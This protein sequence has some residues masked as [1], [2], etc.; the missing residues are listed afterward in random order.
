M[1]GQCR[2]RTG[3]ELL[4]LF[5]SQAH[6]WRKGKTLTADITEGLPVSLPSTHL[7][8]PCC[9]LSS[10][11]P[12]FLPAPPISPPPFPRP[13]HLPSFLS[14]VFSPSV[15]LQSPGFPSLRIDL[16]CLPTFLSL[17]AGGYLCARS[18]GAQA[19]YRTCGLQLKV[20]VSII[21]N[22]MKVMVVV[23]W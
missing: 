13:S 1:T 18:L 6:S 20:E 2:S 8:T 10:L 12:T 11:S 17:K 14:V 16:L 3:A 4:P 15:S 23:V 9:P 19:T 7:S 22:E 21:Q 5:I